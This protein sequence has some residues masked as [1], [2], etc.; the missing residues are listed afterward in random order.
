VPRLIS[1]LNGVLKCFFPRPYSTPSATPAE[2][3]HV[4]KKL[5]VPYFPLEIL[6]V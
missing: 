4:P 1:V 3:S 5:G 6:V 2:V